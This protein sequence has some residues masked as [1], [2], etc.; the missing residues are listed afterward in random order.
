MTLWVENVISGALADF[1]YATHSDR[2][3]GPTD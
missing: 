3:A 2:T 1:G